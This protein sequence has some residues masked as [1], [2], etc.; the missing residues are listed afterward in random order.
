MSHVE[1][2]CNID[3]DSLQELV[4][5]DEEAK[6]ELETTTTNNDAPPLPIT[7]PSPKGREINWVPNTFFVEKQSFTMMVPS[8]HQIYNEKDVG[9]WKN[10]YEIYKRVKEK[11]QR[12]Q[13]NTKSLFSQSL[14]SIAAAAVPAMA[15]SAAQFLFPLI[16]MAFFHD[17][18][19]FDNIDLEKHIKS[20]PSDNTL[21]KHNLHQATRDTIVISRKLRHRKICMACDK[22]NK[23]GIG[24]FV[25]RSSTWDP[26]SGSVEANTIDIDA[27]GGKSNECA[28]SIE[29]SMNKLKDND[30][31]R[32]HLLFGQCTDSGGG[33]VLDSLADELQA[34]E[35][36]ACG[37]DEHLVANCCIH[38]LQLQLRDAVVEALGDGGLDNVNAMQ[39][40][41]T[42]RDLQESLDLEEWR[43]ILCLACQFV[44]TYDPAV[45]VVLTGTK[46]QKECQSEFCD[47]FKT[48]FNCHSK[49][50]TN[51]VVDPDTE[52]CLHTALHKMTEP[53]LTRWWTVGAG[54]NCAFDC[55]PQLCHAAQTVIN[56]YAGGSGPHGIA[57]CLCAHMTNQ[58]NCIDLT[59]IRS[60]HKGH[61]SPHLDWLQSCVDLS[62]T[63]AFQSHSMSARH[64]IMH[65]DLVCLPSNTV[66]EDHTEAIEK[67]GHVRGS[68]EHKRHMKKLTVFMDQSLNALRTHF[69]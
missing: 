34:K 46:S 47:K 64:Y 52:R 17:T 7:T 38:G 54:A 26:I 22:G 59:L 20:F 62:M 10:G 39:L 3:R 30:G 48:T 4:D 2:N 53:I 49:F 57:S 24:H 40:L 36:L 42:V 61:T 11:L 13:F 5:D 31:D 56:I 12:K 69:K 43:H 58:E 65:R 44:S 41:H 8:T 63:Q 1:T 29:S 15:L 60:C 37:P 9:R 32:S 50:K 68:D 23:K 28:L 16:V 14:F 51:E 27:S 18:G 66:F 19:L 35:N 45:P 25:K 21:R 33:G 55:Y 6:Q 67:A